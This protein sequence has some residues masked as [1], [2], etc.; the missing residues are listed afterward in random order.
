MTGLKGIRL[1]RA[2]ATGGE[3]MERS[4]FCE[5]SSILSS[6]VRQPMNSLSRPQSLAITN[7]S[8]QTSEPA[9]AQLGKNL[10]CTI[11]PCPC[12]CPSSSHYPRPVKPQLGLGF[13]ISSPDSGPFGRGSTC[14]SS[15][16]S[17]WMLPRSVRGRSKPIHGNKRPI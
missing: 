14:S 5:S 15:K 13:S 7:T 2:V 11:E 3:S 6:A 9:R 4:V 8:Y 10:L 1:V 16:T 12:P 17:L